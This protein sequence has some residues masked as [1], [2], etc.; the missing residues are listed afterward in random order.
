MKRLLAAATIALF[1][2]GPAIGTACEY[3]DQTS[4]STT[5]PEQ[6]VSTPVP[7]ATKVI[8]AKVTPALTP[9]AAK[10][11]VVKAKAPSPEQ[12]VAAVTSN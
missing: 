10:P 4:A 8:S 11:N 5:P 12:K 9:K 7:A 2:L 6:L 3:M 1:G